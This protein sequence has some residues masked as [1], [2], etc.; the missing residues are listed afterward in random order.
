MAAMFI[1]KR[2]CR[3]YVPLFYYLLEILLALEIVMFLNLEVNLLDLTLFSYLVVG[4]TALYR[5]FRMVE[6]YARSCPGRR[7]A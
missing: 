5:M 2:K 1:E 6:V 7:Y 4:L 3:K